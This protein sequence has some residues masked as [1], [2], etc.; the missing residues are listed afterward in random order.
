MFFRK[1]NPQADL[2]SI[3]LSV[4]LLSAIQKRAGQDPT[5]S[6]PQKTSIESY[7]GKAR[8]KRFTTKI[9]NTKKTSFSA[10]SFKQHSK[11]L[12][13]MYVQNFGQLSSTTSCALSFFCRYGLADLI[14][15]TYDASSVTSQGMPASSRPNLCVFSLH[16]LGQHAKCSILSSLEKPE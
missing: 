10:R 2:I 3:V 4:K 11:S 1:A 8:N 6:Q 5:V 7:H 15:M 13:V 14:P 9:S 16:S 12:P